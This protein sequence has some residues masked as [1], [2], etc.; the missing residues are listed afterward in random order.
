M[1]QSLCLGSARGSSSATGMKQHL[2]SGASPHPAPHPDPIMLL[3]LQSP[4][5]SSNMLQEGDAG[6]II[7]T[8]VPLAKA[9]QVWDFFKLQTDVGPSAEPHRLGR[10]GEK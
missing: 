6:V 10:V 8:K 5:C 7:S 4:H 9:R 1:P 2:H 3:L